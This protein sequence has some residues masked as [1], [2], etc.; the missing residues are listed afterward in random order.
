MSKPTRISST[1]SAARDTRMVSPM[2]SINSPPRATE[3]FTVPE[4]KVPASVTPR[5][6]GCS[7]W[8]A[9]LR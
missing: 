4:R 9:S 5:C 7:I 1:G 2:P 3:D 8:L 6:R